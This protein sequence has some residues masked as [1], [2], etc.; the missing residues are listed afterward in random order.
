[1]AKRLPLA[2]AVGVSDVDL[3]AEAALGIGDASHRSYSYLS[4]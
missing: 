2:G 3:V 1:M 4:Q